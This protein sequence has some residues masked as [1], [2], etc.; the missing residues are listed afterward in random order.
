MTTD[1]ASTW[2]LAISRA[3]WIAK[4]AVYALLGLLAILIAVDGSAPSDADQRG[5]L[6][7][8]ADNAAGPVL[9]VV[10]AAG[11][12][13]YAVHRGVGA[14]RHTDDDG[15]V[16]RGGYL[17]SAAWSLVLAW[18]AVKIVSDRGS[19]SGGSSTPEKTSDG[20][21]GTG[22]G[23]F[24]VFAAG[25]VVIVVG[26]VFA[27]RA[28]NQEFMDDIDLEPLTERTDRRV[29]EAF[30][31]FGT[32]GWFGRALAMIAVG[33]F[34]I[35]AAVDSDVTSAAGYDRTLRKLGSH[36]PFGAISVFTVGVLLVIYGTM[37][38]L[39]APFRS[40]S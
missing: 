1:D 3:G 22:W 37:S 10:L 17:V 38:A 20:L 5:A 12:V 29:G 27:Y 26:A 4:G 40:T 2:V 33:A 8:L 31:W 19:Q 36:R 18:S 32:F 25:V 28:V 16:E 24:L 39:S 6:R 30:R 35:I 13:L 15:L 9:L 11:L 23:T 14:V 34:A 21:L 7:L